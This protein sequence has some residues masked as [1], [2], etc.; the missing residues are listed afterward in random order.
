MDLATLIGMVGAC[1]ILMLAIITG[2]SAMIFINLP[3]ILIVVGGSLLVVMIKFSLKDFLGAVKVA[4]AAFKNKTQPSTELIE[5]MLEM[6]KIARK[7]GVLALEKMEIENQFLRDAV[8][9]MVDGTDKETIKERMEKEI[10]QTIE[11]H[12][13]G[14]KIFVA[15]TD[16]APAMGMIGTLIG[17]VQML[18]NMEDPKAI[19]PAMAVALLTTLYGAFIANVIAKPIAD[20]LTLIKADI[21]RNSML[22]IDGVMAIQE[23]LNPRIIEPMLQIYL[24]PEQRKVEGEE[25]AAA[26]QTTEA[27]GAG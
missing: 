25:G 26:A 1:I 13:W 2:G 10:R 7:E 8:M 16:V 23:G 12:S 17:L 18:S 5:Q 20:K 19:G 24:P 9:M 3:S 21:A 6:A 11:R 4:A 22:C 14:A 27:A 15:L